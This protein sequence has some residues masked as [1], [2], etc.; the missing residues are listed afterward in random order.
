M[1]AVNDVQ[2]ASPLRAQQ[3]VGCRWGNEGYLS[4]TGTCFDIGN[5]TESALR[6][7]QRMGTRT[8]VARTP[9]Q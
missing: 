4:S 2:S 5:T 6:R 8:P 3:G 9:R 7:Y 1:P